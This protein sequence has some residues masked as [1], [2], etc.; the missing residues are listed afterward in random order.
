M[1][2]NDD[3]H[4][5]RN[6][7]R[8]ALVLCAAELLLLGAL[9]FPY[10][11]DAF[12]GTF[13]SATPFSVAMYATLLLLAVIVFLLLMSRNLSPPLLKGAG[14]L[15]LIPLLSLGLKWVALLANGMEGMELFH[16]RRGLGMEILG[17]LPNMAIDGLLFLAA[18]GVFISV[19][20]FR[21]CHRGG[22]GTAA[23]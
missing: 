13:F 17:P 3:H 20:T 2:N 23:N 5:L 19:C 14:V 6:R 4:R 7:Q 22:D 10:W 1:T 15:A 9:P 21:S 18:L 11:K 16:H 8:L 12:R